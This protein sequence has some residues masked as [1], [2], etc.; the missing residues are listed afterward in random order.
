MLSIGRILT[1][2]DSSATS[3][4]KHESQGPH[5]VRYGCGHLK[6]SVP[7]GI[8]FL[9]CTLHWDQEGSG[10]SL[11]NGNG[12]K[13]SLSDWNIMVH[14]TS[15]PDKPL[16]RAVVRPGLPPVPTNN[17]NS[18]HLGSSED[19]P[20]S[21]SGWESQALTSLSQQLWEEVPGEGAE[22]C[23]VCFVLGKSGC[24]RG[25]RTLPQLLF[26]LDLSVCWGSQLLKVKERNNAHQ[27]GNNTDNWPNGNNIDKWP[28]TNQ[29]NPSCR[30]VVPA[31]SN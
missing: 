9:A 14:F 11:W 4:Q 20:A 17:C 15:P 2:Y 27:A 12:W 22:D 23:P 7:V 26:H 21:G 16:P 1:E 29:Y 13:I 31:L 30:A 5:T 10:G 24:W 18:P 25:T 6:F 19:S 28:N 3:K 8:T